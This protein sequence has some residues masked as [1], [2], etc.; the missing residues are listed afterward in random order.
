VDLARPDGAPPTPKKKLG[1]Q[2]WRWWAVGIVSVGLVAGT[3]LAFGPAALGWLLAL[4]FYLAVIILGARQRWTDLED[5]RAYRAAAK[6]QRIEEERRAYARVMRQLAGPAP[7]PHEPPLVAF[8]R[9]R[10]FHVVGPQAIAGDR[11][12]VRIAIERPDTEDASVS[13]EVDATNA[14]PEALASLREKLE[15]SGYQLVRVGPNVRLE[16]REKDAVE[17]DAERLDDVLDT[18]VDACSPGRGGTYR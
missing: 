12:G 16:W 17:L 6:V 10:G 18:V 9:A 11:G 8:A 7:H 15:P 2:W 14:T 4:S 13:L 1:R 3:L 5:D